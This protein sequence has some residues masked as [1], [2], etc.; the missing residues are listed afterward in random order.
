MSNPS[1]AS[2]LPCRGRRQEQAARLAHR[3]HRQRYPGRQCL[4]AEIDEFGIPRN[5]RS[6]GRSPFGS[7]LQEAWYPAGPMPPHL[8]PLIS[9]FISDLVHVYE[10]AVLRAASDALLGLGV[11]PARR[12]PGRSPKAAGAAGRGPG[13]PPKPK[14][15]TSPVSTPRPKPGVQVS[16]PRSEPRFTRLPP[17]PSPRDRSFVVRKAPSNEGSAGGA[18]PPIKRVRS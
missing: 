13:R 2:S 3:R 8:R 11:G 12:R 10:T 7:R 4:L 16:E 17:G 14:P 15:R 1:F 5:K 18:V 9:R 6:N